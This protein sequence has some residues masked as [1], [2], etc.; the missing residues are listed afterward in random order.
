MP[1]WEETMPQSGAERAAADLLTGAPIKAGVIGA[2]VFGTF[3]ARKYANLPGV[4]LA[5]VFDPD[6]ERGGRLAGEL[7]ATAFTDLDAFLETVHV[8]T[9][10]SPAD[11]H[12]AMARR[13]LLAGRHAYVEKPLATAVDEGV[14]LVELARARQLVLACG[15][16]ERLTFAAMGLLQAPEAPLRLESVRRGT[17]NDRNRDVSCVLD[18][19]IHDL[20][21]GLTLAGEGA[22]EVLAAG[23]FDEARAEVRFPGGLIG[24]FEA[25]RVAQARERTMRIVYPSGVVEIDFLKPAFDNRTGFSLDEAFATTPNGRDPLG[26]CVSAFLDA[27]RGNAVRPAVS[28]E[29]GL[30]ALTLALSVERGMGG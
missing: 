24:V 16:Q 7:G 6:A 21:L 11:S 29:E 8:V 17:P 28:G 19:M 23:G 22:Y 2:G 14:A 13:V 27:V 10:A 5:A 12:A 1:I 25:S 15:H 26:A 20:D 30:R 9:I 4:A 18:L 3:H